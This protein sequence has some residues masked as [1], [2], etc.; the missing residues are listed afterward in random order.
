MCSKKY[1]YSVFGYASDADVAKNWHVFRGR[2]RVFVSSVSHP[3][4]MDFGAIANANHH[5]LSL[6][7][8][9]AESAPTDR[10]RLHDSPGVF[11][12]AT[13]STFHA[14]FYLHVHTNRTNVKRHLFQHMTTRMYSWHRVRQKQSKT[15]I[16]G[17]KRWGKVLLNMRVYLNWDSIKVSYKLAIRTWYGDKLTT[18]IDLSRRDAEGFRSSW[19]QTLGNKRASLY[20]RNPHLRC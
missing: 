20:N 1:S 16:R 9:E 2:T 4:L 14:I 11:E 6:F 3:P 10:V 7:D 18:S 13:N 5:Q 12:P 8:S 17:V 19:L 15:G